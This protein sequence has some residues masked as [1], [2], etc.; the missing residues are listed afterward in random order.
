MPGGS[1]VG[2]SPTRIGG[3]ARGGE[4]AARAFEPQTIGDR[5]HLVAGV[6]LSQGGPRAREGARQGGTRRLEPQTRADRVADH[7]I[8]QFAR[9]SDGDDRLARPATRLGGR[10]LEVLPRRTEAVERIGRA[11]PAAGRGDLH[12]VVELRARRGQLG[13]GVLGSLEGDA[14]GVFDRRR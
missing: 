2:Q 11:L 5:T 9:A 3:R 4:L 13:L 6:G 1:S 10:A 12:G 7:L 14:M 8:A